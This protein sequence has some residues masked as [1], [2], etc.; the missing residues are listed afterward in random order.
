MK[1][2]QKPGQN[3]IRRIESELKLVSMQSG[4]KPVT[5]QSAQQ[6]GK[7]KSELQLVRKQ[8]GTQFKSELMLHA[9]WFNLT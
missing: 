8:C 2:A 5:K 3:R 1:M 7:I 6:T 4:A 9:V